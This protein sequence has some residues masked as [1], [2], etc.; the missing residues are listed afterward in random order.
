MPK[1]PQ[2]LITENTKLGNKIVK[3]TN[4]KGEAP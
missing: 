4:F 2:Y 3:I 1:K